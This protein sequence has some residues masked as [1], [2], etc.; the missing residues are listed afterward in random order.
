MASILWFYARNTAF[1][2]QE[3]DYHFSADITEQ[4]NC[5]GAT[6][7]TDCIKQKLPTVNG[8]FKAL[9]FGKSHPKMYAQLT[10]EHPID[11]WR[12]QVANAYMGKVGLINSGG[13]SRGCC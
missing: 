3:A 4:A 11:L 1:R 5:L 9:G 6:L 13:T 7:Q 8:D 10:T 12:Y 2:T